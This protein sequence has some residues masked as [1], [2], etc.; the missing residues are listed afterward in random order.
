MA[1]A[2]TFLK[3]NPDDHKLAKNMKYYKTLL[4]VE[5]HLVDHEEQP[6]EV[7]E[8][9]RPPSP[10][11][12]APHTPAASACFQSVFLKSVTLYNSGDFSNSARSMEE[13]LAQYFEAYHGCVAG[14]EGSYEILEAKDFYPTLAGKSRPPPGRRRRQAQRPG[15]C[16]RLAS[17]LRSLHGR[18]ELQGQL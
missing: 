16:L 10:A 2:H 11:R 5:E 4:D 17:P 14:C 15:R 1:A 3:R 12:A 7:R 6:Y 8:P 13:A 9:A 18:S